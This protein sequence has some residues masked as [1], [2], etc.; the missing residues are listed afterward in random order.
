MFVGDTHQMYTNITLFF[1]YVTRL[2]TEKP[3]I[4]VILTKVFFTLLLIKKKKKI[5]SQE[6]KAER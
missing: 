3:L 1:N 6:I 2:L 4:S 5:Y